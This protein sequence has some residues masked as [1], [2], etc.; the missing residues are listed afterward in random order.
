MVIGMTHSHVRDP[1]FLP[2]TALL[3]ALVDEAPKV[4]KQVAKTAARNATKAGGAAAA[5]ALGAEGKGAQEVDTVGEVY[6]LDFVANNQCF[7]CNLY[8]FR[9][10]CM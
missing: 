10:S 7:V 2:G 5:T 1:T 4:V 9:D 8:V 3:Q 6:K